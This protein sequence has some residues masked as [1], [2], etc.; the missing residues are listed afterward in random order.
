[1][2]VFPKKTV[3]TRQFIVFGLLLPG[4]SSCQA[5]SVTAGSN[6]AAAAATAA[7]C[8]IRARIIGAL[9]AD[10]AWTGTNLTCEGMPRPGGAGARLKFAG[11]SPDGG[12]PIAIIIAVPDLV[13]NEAARELASNVTLI[14][15]GGGRFFST[16]NLDICMTDIHSSQELPGSANRS[17]VSGAVYCV[18]PL[19]Q[20]NGKSSVSIP[21]LSFTGLIDWS[22]S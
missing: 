15:E 6:P 21:Q 4:M 20:V 18:A 10:I 17:S 5:D 9:S 7:D 14:E 3:L 1:L 2:Q 12:R 8:E 22:S 13:R 16:A 11:A 19:A